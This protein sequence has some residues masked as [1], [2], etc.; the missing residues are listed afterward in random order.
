[1][2]KMAEFLDIHEEEVQAFIRPGGEVNDLLNDVARDAKLLARRYILTGKYGSRHGMGHVRSGR[3]LGGIDHNRTKTTGPLTGYSRI[4]SAAK[5]TGYFMHGT[6]GPITAKH[7]PYMLVPKKAGAM[8]RSPA[9][10]G[11][12][13][14]LYLAWVAGGKKRGYRGFYRPTEVS[15]QKKKPFLEDAKRESMRMHKLPT[16]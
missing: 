7:G 8:Q 2:T 6:T 13:H 5:H 10:K 16:R 12:G 11:A 4:Y 9:T 3:L 14:E 15:G 1:M